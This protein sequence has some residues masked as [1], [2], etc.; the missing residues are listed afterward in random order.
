MINDIA[1]NGIKIT[2]KNPKFYQSSFGSVARFVLLPMSGNKVQ[3]IAH[4]IFSISI[5]DWFIS[6][7]R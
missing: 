4:N 6:N 3:M 2:E 5:W 1:E 7:D